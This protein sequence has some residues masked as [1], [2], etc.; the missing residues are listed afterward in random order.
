[1]GL[2]LGGYNCVEA[3]YDIQ[4]KRNGVEQ[5]AGSG[6]YG[7]VRPC[8][9][10]ATHKLRAVKTIEK[11][12]WNTRGHVLNE[13]A[14]LKRVAGRHPNII[15]FI[16]YFEE[17]GVMNLIFEFCPKGTLDDCIKQCRHQPV[18]SI[19]AALLWQVFNALG[20]LRGENIVHRDVK[21]ANLLFAD[22]TTLKLADFGTATAGSEPLKVAEGTPAFFAPEVY[23]LPK[24]KGYSFPVDVWAAGVTLFMFLFK[25]VHPFDDRGVVSKPRLF[26]GDFD[27]GWLTSSN[28]SDLLEWLLM[29]NPDQRILV[30]DTLLHPWFAANRLG[31]GGLSKAR[32]RRKL[33]LDSHGNWMMEVE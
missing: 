16:E 18:E 7:E 8:T 30:E 11:T 27:V 6:S 1:M 5:A 23:Q 26:C 19:G 21:P 17:W 13:I 12:D 4:Y 3:D 32:P 22:E 31:A 20:F 24:G 33:I 2:C 29:P 28:V 15:E 9:H 14:I 25:G 10:T